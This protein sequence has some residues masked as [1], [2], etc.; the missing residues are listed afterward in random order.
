MKPRTW[1]VLYLVHWYCLAVSGVM[2]SLQIP[3]GSW[4][5]GLPWTSWG[6]ELADGLTQGDP[7]S[8]GAL[9]IGLGALLMALGVAGSI[10]A[11]LL[12]LARGVDAAAAPRRDGPP[13]S[14][15]EQAREAAGLVEDPQV[16]RLIQQLNSRLG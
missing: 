15:S 9:W 2:L 8:G 5:S 3:S 4:L 1:L 13:A 11:S 7:V 14:L 12:R 10:V 6:T 16:R